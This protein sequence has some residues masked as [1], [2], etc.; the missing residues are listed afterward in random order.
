[1]LISADLPRQAAQRAVSAASA[2]LVRQ[3]LVLGPTKDGGCWLIGLA[4]RRRTPPGLLAGA[5]RAGGDAIAAILVRVP[6]RL[7]Q[8]ELLALED[9][10]RLSLR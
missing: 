5:G 2:A 9:F 4:R 1:L 10:P 7:W 8:V 6:M 3:D